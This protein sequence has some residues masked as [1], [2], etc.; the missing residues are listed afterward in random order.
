MQRDK[1]N[2]K[3]KKERFLDKAV[4]LAFPVI[5]TI[6]AML[7]AVI[8]YDGLIKEP[9][10]EPYN[11]LVW[12]VQRIERVET[13]TGNVNV[14]F[15]YGYE[16]PSISLGETLP[17]RGLRCNNDTEDVDVVASMWWKREDVIGDRIVVFEDFPDTIVPGCITLTFEND[18]PTEVSGMMV[19]HEDESQV[20]KITGSVL[21]TKEGGVEST[22]VT[23]SFILVNPHINAGD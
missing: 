3:P 2:G 16:Q 21:P 22:F 8:V 4:K 13:D 11:P 12:E 19:S 23:E 6:T 10:I 20:W 17:A 14:P 7:L 15:V 9:T 18:I 1:F 5:V